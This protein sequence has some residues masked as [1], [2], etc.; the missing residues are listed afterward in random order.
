LQ[1][2]L[3]AYC[4]RDVEA[5]M[6]LD[7]RLPDLPPGERAIWEMDLF[8]NSRGIHGDIPLA[9]QASQIAA[10]TTAA[11]NARLVALTAG[12]VDSASRVQAIKRYMEAKGIT[13]VESLDKQA[14]TALLERED[15]DPTVREVLAVR[16]QVGK[17]ST[18]KYLS[19]INSADH[20]DN[21]I[22]G[23]IQY[24]GAGTGRWSGRLIQPQNFPQGLKPAAQE[25]AISAIREGSEWF[26]LIYGDKSM[27]TL[28]GTLRGCLTAAEGKRLVVAD[29]SAIEARV[30]FWLAKD[31]LALGMYKLGIS[32]YENMAKAVFNRP[33]TKQDNPQ[34]YKLG[35]ALV[36]GAGY[37]MG[38]NKFQATALG[39]GIEVTEELALRAIRAYREKFKP[40]VQM[41]YSVE[42]AAR[43]AVRIPGSVQSC[44]ADRVLWGMDKAREFLCCKLPSGRHLRYFRPS[45]KVIDGPRG[46]KEEIHYW[47]SG[48]GGGLEEFKT[49][50]GSL[51]ENIDQATARDIMASGML[52]CEAAGYPI[53]LT[54]HDE[55]V[56]EVED[57]KGSVKDFVRL[58]CDL[59]AWAEGC[60]IEAEGW[61]DRRYHK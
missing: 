15:L 5:E 43:A 50:G 54:V 22:R 24:H 20:R 41:W 8:I 26:N 27:D 23:T 37:G 58:M 55:I 28:S 60:P 3:I 57:G 53:V 40:V 6:D 49:Y 61:E 9:R 7:R 35:K 16:R 46:E 10:T 2:Q 52:K 29:Y 30:L 31:E 38:A 13:G 32:L 44:C 17:S 1:N 18:A 39:W 56:A 48:L 25:D 14:V 34:E 42:A 59:P 11:L 47:T 19:V 51:V 21:R 33:V 12:A 36:L 4:A 45:L